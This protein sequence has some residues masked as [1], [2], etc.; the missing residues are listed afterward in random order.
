L[1]LRRTKL[2]DDTFGPIMDN[3]PQKIIKLDISHNT[4]LT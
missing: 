1:I 3:F 4:D 2:N